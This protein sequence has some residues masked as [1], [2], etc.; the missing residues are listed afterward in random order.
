[1]PTDDELKA[2]FLAQ[3][4]VTKCPSRKPANPR[5]RIR[6]AYQPPPEPV[7]YVGNIKA[8]EGAEKAA[9]VRR[10]AA[11]YRV[12]LTKQEN[13]AARHAARKLRKAWH[14]KIEKRKRKGSITIVLDI[15]HSCPEPTG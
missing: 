10:R 5:I 8:D 7:T 9:I 15:S 4:G 13:A 1:M 2:E 11:R 3:H 6:R 12:K 14:K